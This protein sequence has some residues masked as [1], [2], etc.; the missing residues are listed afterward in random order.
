MKIKNTLI[1]LACV[2]TALFSK[3]E[4]NAANQCD[5]VRVIMRISDLVPGGSVEGVRKAAQL[6]EAWY[7]SNGVMN[8][9][10]VVGEL[11][12]NDGKNWIADK[13]KVIS[14][15]VNT[16]KADEGTAQKNWGDAGFKEFVIEYSKNNKVS[17]EFIACFP[18]GVFAGN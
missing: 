15:H 13:S 7:R 6:H 9:R 8:N 14:L 4:I 18:K 5:G 17:N 10:Q 1:G 16:P 3:A 12:M 11:Y 2:L